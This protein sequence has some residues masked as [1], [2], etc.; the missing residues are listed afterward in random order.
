MLLTNR[1]QFGGGVQTI[2]SNATGSIFGTFFPCF[3]PIWRQ[4]ICF[5]PH[6][7]H[8]LMTRT[9][10]LTNIISSILQQMTRIHEIPCTEHFCNAFFMFMGGC[11]FVLFLLMKFIVAINLALY[12]KIIFYFHSKK[13]VCPRNGISILFAIWWMSKMNHKTSENE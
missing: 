8:E 7:W 11:A 3:I 13:N 9:M 1:H 10:T 6:F 12:N 2:N 5:F 4:N